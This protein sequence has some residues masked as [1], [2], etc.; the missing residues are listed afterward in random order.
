VLG[1]GFPSLAIAQEKRREEKRGA[2]QSRGSAEG[3]P[4]PS[5]TPPPS[6][7]IL[8]AE[9]KEE[10]GDPPDLMSYLVAIEKYNKGNP[11]GIVIPPAFVRHWHNLRVS[12]AWYKTG[13]ETPIPNDFSARLGD[14]KVLARSYQQR[15]E[16]ASFATPVAA[17]AKKETA[18]FPS[19]PVADYRP[20]ARETIGWTLAPDDQTPWEALSDTLRRDWLRHW[21]CEQR[22]QNSQTA[23]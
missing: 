13:S 6:D 9:K 12:T 1:K 19:C 10:G 17:A 7:R 23:A 20:F 2:E 8:S 15:S 22:K 16:L 21:D 11:D 18:P 5:S 14:L 4:N 3:E